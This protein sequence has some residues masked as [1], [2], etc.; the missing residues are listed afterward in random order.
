M[1]IIGMVMLASMLLLA[2]CAATAP[3]AELVSARA[4]YQRASTGQA[5]QLVPAEVHKAEQA[6]V[7][8]EKS[9]KDEPKSFI[10]RD[11]AYV[12][13]RK[14]RL[15]EALAVTAAGNAA[16]AAA[17]TSL[18]ATQAEIA[19]TAQV[20]LAASE[21]ANKQKDDQ[22]AIEQNARREA[23]A[24][25]AAAQAD[26]VKLA[27]VKEEARGLVVTLSG[28][29]LFASN[30][31]ELLP[32]ARERLNQVAT[33]LLATKDRRLTVEGYT[34]SRGTADHNMGL[35]QKRADAVRSYIIS[36]GYAGELV[37]A[38]GRGETQPVADNASSEGRANNRR[39]EIV[40]NRP[41]QK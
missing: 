2:G 7:L 23:D 11:L 41:V 25:A 1:K 13:D 32:A 40:I 39:V 29:V 16:T 8:A 18:E 20:N 14:A 22:L 9:F 21:Q 31:S 37:L 4:S 12:A 36:R 3:P 6:L 35:S 30:R 34:D 15:A 24:R 17:K 26:L 19:K 33:A 10:T 38:S 27:G 28:S 5:Q